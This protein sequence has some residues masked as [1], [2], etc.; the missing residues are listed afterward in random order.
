MAVVKYLDKR[1]LTTLAK[2]IK[3]RVTGIYTIKGSA[4]YVDA[5]HVGKLDVDGV[6]G[7]KP[8]AV[9]VWKIVDSKWE[10]VETFKPGDVFNIEN[11]FTTDK[12]FIEGVGK[13]IVAGINIVVVNTGTDK[14]PVLKFDMMAMGV[15]LDAYQKKLLTKPLSV[16]DTFIDGE[17][18]TEDELPETADGEPEVNDLDVAKLEDGTI[19][20]ASVTGDDVTWVK[21]G[22]QDTVE[23]SLELLSSVAPNTPISDKEIEE[24]F[25]GDVTGGIPGEE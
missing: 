25:E 7:D 12:N 18:E 21:I 20:R 1:G 6:T 15:S 23:G 14:K 9:G 13:E 5:D 8:D 17:Y 16:F 11:N 3:R 4:Y 10:Q 19:Y 2:E 24:L 22:D